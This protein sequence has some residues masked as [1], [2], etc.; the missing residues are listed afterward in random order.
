MN[1]TSAMKRGRSPKSEGFDHEKDHKC[2]SLWDV[3]HIN[4]CV[5][6]QAQWGPC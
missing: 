6:G 2:D 1:G 3:F 4:S 5:R